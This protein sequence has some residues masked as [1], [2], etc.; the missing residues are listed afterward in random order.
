MGCSGKTCWRRLVAWHT[1]RGW[2]AWHRALLEQFREADRLDWRRALLDSAAVR[3]RGGCGD[4]AQTRRTAARPAPS[5]SWSA[6]LRTCRLA[7]PAVRPTGT[8]AAGWRQCWM[9][10]RVSG[11]ARDGRAAARIHCTPTRPTTIAAAARN[12]APAASRRALPGAASTAASVSADT[13]G[14]S[15]AA[16]LASLSFAALPSVTGDGPMP[17]SPSPHSL[18]PS[19]AS[20]RLGSLVPGS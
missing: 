15:N 8:T 1:A 18:A 10:C 2:A 16:W 3:A 11:A 13:A 9:R 6:M 4:R 20:G 17:I 12:A 14:P 19:S 7:R 5:G